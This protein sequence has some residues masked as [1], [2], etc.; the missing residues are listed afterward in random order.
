[1]MMACGFTGFAD[2][3]DVRTR[4]F[5]TKAQCDSSVG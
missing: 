2:R 5:R 1:M 3:L 4:S